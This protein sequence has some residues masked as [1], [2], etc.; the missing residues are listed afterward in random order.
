MSNNRANNRKCV[1]KAVF[2][3]KISPKPDFNIH[4]S[5]FFSFCH[6]FYSLFWNCWWYS[7]IFY[8][9]TWKLWV[10]FIKYENPKLLNPFGL[11]PRTSAPAFA[12][13]F[14]FRFGLCSGPWA[15]HKHQ[16]GFNILDFRIS[17]NHPSFQV[18]NQ[19]ICVKPP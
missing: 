18:F 3:F 10:V 16:M 7:R 15:Q 9:K 17:W 4:R 1:G 8:M 12:P 2:L 14:K 13:H 19:K 5:Y 11:G 6:V